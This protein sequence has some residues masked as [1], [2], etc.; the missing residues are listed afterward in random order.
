MDDMRKELLK[1]L[2]YSEKAVDVLDAELHYGELDGPTISVRHQA[3]CGDVLML[4]LRIEENIIRDAAFRF[5]GCS[6]LQASASGV[7]EMVIGK[8]IDEAERI[9]MQ[10]IVDWLEGLPRNK[11]ECAEASSITLHKAIAEYRARTKMADS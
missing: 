6:G 9:E 5:V 2:G 4:D 11:F 3:G 1:A 8:S 7:A 10:D